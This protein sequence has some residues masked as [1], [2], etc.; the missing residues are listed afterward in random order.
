MCFGLRDDTPHFGALNELHAP[1][2]SLPAE[3]AWAPAERSQPD[4]GD[5]PAA[6]A[7]AHLGRLDE[8]RAICALETVLIEFFNIG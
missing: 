1:Q 2:I 6:R 3:D 4:A 7:N 8:A 5:N